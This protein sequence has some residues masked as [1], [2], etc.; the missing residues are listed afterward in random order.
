MTKTT[1]SRINVITVEDVGVILHK[2]EVVVDV[3]VAEV[4]VVTMVVVV[5]DV[6]EHIITVMIIL[7][8]LIM[9]FFMRI[10]ML[11]VIKDVKI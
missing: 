1:T 10:T 5:E 11:K 9:K 7:R 6:G 8:C 4:M 3:V 2:A